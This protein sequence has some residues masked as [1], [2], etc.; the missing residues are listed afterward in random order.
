MLNNSRKKI[1]QF[2]LFETLTTAARTM[3]SVLWISSP[4]LAIFQKDLFIE[5]L[6]KKKQGL[7]WK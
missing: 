5:P 6:L 3:T 1:G 7:Q 2:A 4:N